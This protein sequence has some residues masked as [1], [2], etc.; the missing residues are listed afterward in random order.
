MMTTPAKIMQLCK[1]DIDA[2]IAELQLLEPSP[3]LMKE[4]LQSLKE[5]L[6]EGFNDQ[7]D[8]EWLVE[9]LTRG[10]DAILLRGWQEQGLDQQ[11][12]CAL[13]AV[14]GY[15]R[16]E[17]HPGSDIDIMVLLEEEANTVT[18]DKISAFFTLLW[19]LQLDLGHSVRTL[20][21]CQEEGAE[22]LTIATTLFES[23]LLG[24][25]ERLFKQLTF[26]ANQ[27]GFWPS[28][29]FFSAKLAEQKGRHARFGDTA[30]RVEPNIKESP[31]GLRDLQIL[32]WIITRHFG[33]EN[34][35]DLIEQG[36]VT[37]E[38]CELLHETKRFLWRVRFGLHS[39]A[40][41]KE[42]RLL[43]DYQKSLA[44]DFGLSDLNS[45]LAVEQLMQQYFRVVTDVQR[46]NE[47]LLQLFE[48]EIS[49][50]NILSPP[51][52][53]NERFQMRG[54][55]VEIVS[56]H[57]FERYPPAL[58]EI[59]LLLQ[60][61]PDAL[62]VRATT[63]RA[64]RANLHL[65]NAEFRRDPICRHLFMEILS[66]PVGVYHQLRRMNTY[67]VL[68]A[69]LPAFGKIVGRMQFD[70]YHNYTVD[71]HTIM[72]L[73][74][75]RRLS[76][77][78]YADEV[79]QCSEIVQRIRRPVLLY[80]AALFHD[81]AKGRGGDHSQLGAADARQ[82]CE[83]HGLPE[84][85]SD[86]VVWL[87]RQHL[88]MSLVAQRKDISDP[89]VINE[90]A[91]EMETEERLNYL[92]LLTVSDIRG[93]GPDLWTSWKAGLLAELYRNTRAALQHKDAS[94][95]YVNNLLSTGDD[96]LKLLRNSGIRET[97][98][99]KFWALLGTEYFRQ[100]SADSIAW[101]TCTVLGRGKNN[102]ST[103]VDVRPVG[104]HGTTEIL[105]YTQN[106]PHC[107][108]IAAQCITQLGLDILGAGV[109]TTDAG[110]AMNVF[111][112]LE[113]DNQP[114]EDFHRIEEISRR[115]IFA[116]E[117]K[118]NHSVSI[119][120]LTP[121]RQ[122]RSFDSP[123]RIKFENPENKSFSELHIDTPDRPGLLADI[124]G[125]L[126]QANLSI[127]RAFIATVSEKAED[128]LHVTDSDGNE[129]TQAQQNA[130]HRQLTDT[131]QTDTATAG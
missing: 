97:D 109:Y 105:V 129:L 104:E 10:M 68:A 113:R 86:L 2:W 23:R 50:Q 84:T 120:D 24:G 9:Q 65:I 69:Y 99:M 6:H 45:N 75:A 32:R 8:I 81:I 117:D 126:E 127:T 52:T 107:F 122:L 14:G 121:S 130:L 20:E 124:A 119:L 71:E 103:I 98:A 25:S 27:P 19:D 89:D 38:E 3:L 35:E 87:V 44:A 118:D 11:P 40:G 1:N 7:L 73:R 111:N 41:R 85:D 110:M 31:G 36:F 63:I 30:Y 53:L 116:L 106:T 18:G 13:L 42:D 33:V 93:T 55:Y 114:C 70:L 101:H 26:L 115:M 72:V 37:E 125:V 57:V 39:H 29:A 56:A 48:E 100:Q 77:E 59:F 28:R 95:S 91:A 94:H 76:V 51:I 79:P 131:L 12:G 5:M 34:I 82:F 66:R 62:G 96:A 128:V 60:R 47:M 16:A 54:G 88:R 123:T 74:Y 43:F 21:T 15:G 46:L 80:L 112:V 102:D 67:G 92:Y 108:R 17:L 90:F 64:I 4:H 83:R 49:L 78:K 22:D 61:N 58:L